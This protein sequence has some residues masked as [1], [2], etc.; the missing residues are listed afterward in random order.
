VADHAASQMVTGRFTSPD[1]V[2]GLVLFL[3]S[4]HASN[5]TGADFIIDGGLIQTL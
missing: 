3:A 4:D 5:I 1:E 2:A